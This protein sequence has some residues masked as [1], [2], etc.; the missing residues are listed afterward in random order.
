[1]HDWDIVLLRICLCFLAVSC[2]YGG[3]DDFGMGACWLDQSSQTGEIALV[4]PVCFHAIFAAPKMPKRRASSFFATL[5]LFAIHSIHS[6]NPFIQSYG[7]LPIFLVDVFFQI[8]LLSQEGRKA[9]L[10]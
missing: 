9:R 5:G 8:T 7:D 1:M 6:P 4:I 2:G 10:M 3:D